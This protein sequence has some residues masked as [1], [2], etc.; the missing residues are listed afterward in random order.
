MC[1]AELANP[2]TQANTR[3]PTPRTYNDLAVLPLAHPADPTPPPHPTPPPRSLHVDAVLFKRPPVLAS[4][5]MLAKRKVP[6]RRP[7]VPPFPHTDMRVDMIRVTWRVRVCA[8]AQ[9]LVC[10][11]T[12]VLVCVLVRLCACVLVCLCVCAHTRAFP[13]RGRGVCARAYTEL[14]PVRMKAGHT[15]MYMSIVI[16]T[17]FFCLSFYMPVAQG[18]GWKPR[19]RRAVTSRPNSSF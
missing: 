7:T 11:C 8:C 15:P 6:T 12:C 2:S 16:R 1:H 5:A 3:M 10:V 19:R 17:F 9:V 4:I 14:C 18:D 13:R